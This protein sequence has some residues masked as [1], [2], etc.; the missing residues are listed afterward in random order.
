[1]NRI[2]NSSSVTTPVRGLGFV[3]GV[4][5]TAGLFCLAHGLGV[6]TALQRWIIRQEVSTS[7]EQAEA[8]AFMALPKGYKSSTTET[9]RL[10]EAAWLRGGNPQLSAAQKR[11]LLDEIAPRL[12]YIEESNPPRI[13]AEMY[14]E[15][16]K[17]A[18]AVLASAH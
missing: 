4:L 18:V 16:F 5:L 3:E 14:R 9:A 12:N 10:V 7:A 11:V 1:M 13:A 17:G 2:S 8:S 15:K 6:D